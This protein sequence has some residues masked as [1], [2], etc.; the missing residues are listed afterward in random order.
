MKKILN[1]LLS[2]LS[3][4]SA[5][6]AVVSCSSKN[7]AGN[8]NPGSDQNTPGNGDK[9]SNGDGQNPGSGQVNP[10]P[11]DKPGNGNKP[12]N[13]GTQNPSNT[14]EKTEEELYKEKMKEL[15]SYSEEFANLALKLLEINN[16]D[17]IKLINEYEAKVKNKILNGV[18][19]SQ[20]AESLI[21]ITKGLI[22]QAKNI[23][24]NAGTETYLQKFQNTLELSKTILNKV[25]NPVLNFVQTEYDALNLLIQK[26]EKINPESVSQIELEGLTTQLESAINNLIMAV[27]PI[28]AKFE[29]LNVSVN[30]I[31]KLIA[32]IQNKEQAEA[33]S[34]ELQNEVVNNISK[35]QNI[36]DLNALISKTAK[37]SKAVM[38]EISKTDNTIKPK[39]LEE[40]QMMVKSINMTI[41]QISAFNPA[42]ANEYKAIYDNLSK[43][44]NENSSLEQILDARD[45]IIEIMKEMEKIAL[46]HMQVI[47]N[48]QKAIVSAQNG[49]LS[50]LTKPIYNALHSKLSLAIIDLTKNTNK[51]TA[52]LEKLLADFQKTVAEVSEEKNKIDQE[53]EAQQ[54]QQAVTEAK[55]NVNSLVSQLQNK[56]ATINAYDAEFATQETAK[57][58][59]AIKGLEA[60]N[61]VSEIQTVKTNVE[62]VLNEVNTYLNSRN[63]KIEELNNAN[64]NINN[65]ISKY[66]KPLYNTGENNILQQATVIKEL[67][68]NFNN[69]SLA[70]L[71]ALSQQYLEKFNAL[72]QTLNK[73]K[74]DAQKIVDLGNNIKTTLLQKP[75]AE[76]NEEQKAML[77]YIETLPLGNYELIQGSQVSEILEKLTQFQAKLNTAA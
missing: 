44:I 64:L 28:E 26:V 29:A 23:L 38:L 76:L 6:V 20:E 2:G 18:T 4:T 27:S 59:E 69:L 66:N 48:I 7:D 55:N 34:N 42:K 9:P 8:K 22:E 63:K 65:E 74:E 24:A 32:S 49:I 51:P 35:A 54:V 33:F 41:E 43:N 19:T 3:I 31:K 40:F 30:N 50:E 68:A 36:D 73:L 37:I 71:E 75:E 72:Q 60:L 45:N 52:E 47:K 67:L 61:S 70:Q 17:G 39:V 25:N 16:L 53:Q 62:A 21:S 15:A 1:L 77:A 11:E 10:N 13:D 5:T 12:S 14:P 58:N 56:I 57:L 46:T